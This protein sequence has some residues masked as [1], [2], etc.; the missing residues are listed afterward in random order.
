MSE[1]EVRDEEEQLVCIVREGP[2]YLILC[3]N[4]CAC[5]QLSGRDVPTESRTKVALLRFSAFSRGSL[6]PSDAVCGWAIRSISFRTWRLSLARERTDLVSPHSLLKTQMNGRHVLS[7]IPPIV[8][9]TAVLVMPPLFLPWIHIITICPTSL[10]TFIGS[11]QMM[12]SSFLAQ[13]RTTT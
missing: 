7:P 5:Y 11:R 4:V 10:N 12:N 6:F 1:T 3:E 9:T 13:R 8:R 2:S